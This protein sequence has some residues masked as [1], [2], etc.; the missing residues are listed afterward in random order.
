MAL[1]PRVLGQ[2]LQW[3]SDAHTPQ[4]CPTECAVGRETLT[5]RTQTPTPVSGKEEECQ[6]R[7]AG[8][9]AQRSPGGRMGTHVSGRAAGRSMPRGE[10]GGG[11]GALRWTCGPGWGGH[12]E[13]LGTR[14]LCWG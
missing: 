12:G 1:H 5:S 4:A 2:P 9:G 7:W 13:C 11:E 3:G 14:E 8:K 10:E 6:A